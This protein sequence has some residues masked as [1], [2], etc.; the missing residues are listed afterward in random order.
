MDKRYIL[1]VDHIE[2]ASAILQ[3][4]RSGP[5]ELSSLLKHTSAALRRYVDATLPSAT[6]IDLAA[7]RARRLTT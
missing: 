1:V 2:Q 7:H 5:I 4:I 3:T 6:V